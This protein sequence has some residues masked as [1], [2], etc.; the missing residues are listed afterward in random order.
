GRVGSQLS[1]AQRS[2]YVQPEPRI[3]GRMIADQDFRSGGGRGRRGGAGQKRQPLSFAAEVDAKKRHHVSPGYG[4][5]QGVADTNGRP[6]G[7]FRIVLESFCIVTS[8]G[9]K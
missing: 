4:A 1:G 6:G 2:I 9:R 5:L 7:A 8:A 3:V